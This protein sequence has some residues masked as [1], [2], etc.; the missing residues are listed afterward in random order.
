MLDQLHV[1]DARALERDRADQLGRVEGD[2]RRARQRLLE[3]HDLLRRGGR[4]A[5]RTPG[6]A[7][8]PGAPWPVRPAAGRRWRSAAGR[9]RRLGRRERGLP[10][11]DD[12]HREDDGDDEI[13]LVHLSDLWQRSADGRKA[14]GGTGIVAAAAPRP[15]AAQAMGGEPASAQR[16]MARHRLGGVGRA[17]GF[18]AAGAD[19]EVGERQLVETDRAAQE[20]DSMRPGNWRFAG[21]GASRRAGSWRRDG[22]RLEPLQ[23]LDQLLAQGGEVAGR[24]PPGGRPAHSRDRAGPRPG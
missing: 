14:G 9:D 23:R 16:A 11:H 3:A 7:G 22:Q 5:R 18:V 13:L 21:A 1:V 4:R 8:W 2:A 10:A 20:Q 6:A 24:G 12:Q 19:E 15:A 17:R